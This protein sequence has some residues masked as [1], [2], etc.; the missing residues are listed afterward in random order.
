MGLS[1]LRAQSASIH[2]QGPGVNGASEKEGERA[3]LGVGVSDPHLAH[4]RNKGDTL[5]GY[6]P[7]RDILLSG[8][9]C[10]QAPKLCP[11]VVLPAL[12]RLAILGYRRPLEERDLW[13]L[14]KEDRSQMVM[15]R[16]LE[17]WNKQHDRAAR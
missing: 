1:S 10:P 14:N 9:P 5:L 4:C 11:S 12:S 6:C 7:P 3:E 17:E 2:H 15:Q 16:L 13:S 8:D